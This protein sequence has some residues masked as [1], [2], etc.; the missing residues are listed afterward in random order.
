[1]TSFWRRPLRRV[2]PE[3]FHDPLGLTLRL[4]RSRNSAAYF[5][6][7]SAALG[8]LATPLDW[9]FQPAERRRYRSAPARSKPLLFVCGPPRSGTTI[10]AS[11]LL[12]HLPFSYFT[13]WT[14]IFPRSPL[15]ASRVFRPLVRGR[16]IS[17]RNYYGRTT[18]F[19][20]P[21]DALY[22]W[23][24][25]L[26]SDRQSAPEHLEPSVRDRLRAFFAACEDATGTAL[27]NK[28]NNLNASAHLVA[29][30]LEQSW[31]VCVERDPLYLAQSLYRARLDIHG[32][33]HVPYGLAD[34]AAPAR[35]DA[36][37]SVLDQVRYHA[38]LASAQEECIG[39]E[40]FWRVSY[41]DFCAAPGQLVDR[42][43]REVLGVA[44]PSEPV[45]PLVPSRKRTL[46][47]KTFETLEKRLQGHPLE[48]S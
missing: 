10:V 7:G 12:E 40:R 32:D 8:L 22:L 25:W 20:G 1:M 28:C 24:R 13:N 31:F 33:A 19:S 30:A 35:S 42:V 39:A 17:G 4:L 11:T 27:L 18:G 44:G 21:N 37:D 26:G 47:E 45:A 38:D 15:V 9:S 5:A 34:P 6:M 14:A 16:R 2:L 23:D 29:E 41:D 36:I 48:Q 3:H 43:S 46:D